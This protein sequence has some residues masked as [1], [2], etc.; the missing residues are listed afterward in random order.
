MDEQELNNLR[1][2]IIRQGQEIKV[3]MNE[4]DALL[5]KLQKGCPHE[6][7]VEQPYVPEVGFSPESQGRRICISCGRVEEERSTR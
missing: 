1:G 3:L 6:V 7:V 4:R 5:A 2:R